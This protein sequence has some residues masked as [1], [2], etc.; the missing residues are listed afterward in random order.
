MGNRINTNVPSLVVQHNLENTSNELAK[1]YTRLSSGQRIAG[2][3]DDAAGLSISDHLQGEIRSLQQAHRNANEG[4]SMVQ[5]AEGSLNEVSNILIRLRELGVQASSDTVDDTERSFINKEYETLKSEI[6]RIASVTTFNGKPLLTGEGS[7]LR[8]QVGSHATEDDAIVYDLG[9]DDVRTSALSISGSN[10][11]TID[12]ATDSLA[13]V[14]E[15]LNRVNAF[16]AGLGANQNRLHSAVN[17][18]TASIENISDAHSR[19]ADTDIA[20]ESSKLVRNT[21]MQSAGVA[22]LAQA[23]NIGNVALK[24]L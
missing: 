11:S 9:S 22:V 16:R 19:I 17:S 24:L 21:I 8:I 7:E 15:A 20:E 14:D 23:N 5:T 1:S 6:D 4:I 18:L 2:A 12:D 13:D 10:V 3:G